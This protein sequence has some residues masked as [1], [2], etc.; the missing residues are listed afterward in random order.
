MIV[1]KIERATLL[2]VAPLQSQKSA[3]LWIAIRRQ[4]APPLRSCPWRITDLGQ[5]HDAQ[6]YCTLAPRSGQPLVLSAWP[7]LIGAE[8]FE[9]ELLVERFLDVE[10]H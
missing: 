2:G 7:D 9:K 4:Y 6:G 1:L 8:R 3:R 10:L 5:N